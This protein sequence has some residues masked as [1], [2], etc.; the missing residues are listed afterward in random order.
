MWR[1]SGF[2]ALLSHNV[3]ASIF[4]QRPAPEF[5]QDTFGQQG[6]DSN[7][8]E[9]LEEALGNDY[10]VAT[11]TRLQNIEEAL[12]PIFAALPKGFSGGKV[13]PPA[14]RY[15]LHRLF[16]QRHGWQV[17]GLAANGETWSGNPASDALA[18]KVP[19]HVKVLF[20]DRL[21]STGLDLHELAVFSSM[22][23]HLIHSE[24]EECL[25]AA[26]NFSSWDTTQVL[27]R[28]SATKVIETYMIIYLSGFNVTK[29]AR[30]RI[31][32]FIDNVEKYYPSWKDTRP[33]LHRVQ[34]EVAH[35]LG[36]YSFDNIMAVVDQVG[37]QFGRFQNQEC[38][39][40]KESLMKL[41]ESN[42]SGRVRVGD[43]YS[44]QWHFS[45]SVDYLRQL[46]ALDESNKANLRVIIPNYLNAPSNC[47]ASSAYYGV[48]CIDDCEELVGQLERKLRAY[49]ASPAEVAAIVRM[50]LADL[51]SASGAGNRTLSKA[52][53]DK[54]Q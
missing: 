18:N 46:G 17:K 37:E 11:E 33:F 2:L 3:L 16:I 53:L 54:L 50:Q 7:I 28:K 14:A 26:Y 29:V 20:D 27:S 42:G 9:Q 31:K 30:A 40:L 1:L 32:N 34:R 44:G 15:A 6:S 48:C 8:L 52:L 38:V 23:E 35:N 10:R 22:L 21:G 19:H 51:P 41:E 5:P 13:G 24:S 36:A 49:T 39:D 4:L 43:F 12:R 47:I 45:E 25:K